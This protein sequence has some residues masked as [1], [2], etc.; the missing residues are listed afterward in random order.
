MSDQEWDAF[1]KD[2]NDS[3][4]ESFWSDSAG[5]LRHNRDGGKVDPA[6]NGYR[7]RR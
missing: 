1:T 2:F 4:P 5:N 6:W 7:S 3:T